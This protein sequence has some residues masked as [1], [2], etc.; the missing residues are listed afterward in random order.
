MATYENKDFFISYHQVDLEWAKWIA[1][2][3]EANGYS[4][5][6]KPWDFRPGSNF[7]LE[8]DNAL[9]QTKRILMVLS[10]DYLAHQSEWTAVVARNPDALLP[11]RVRECNPSGRLAVITSLDL[12]PPIEE[13][14]AR[15][16]LLAGVSGTR[17][18]PSQPP[19][20]P[21]PIPIFPGASNVFI[22]S[23]GDSPVVVSSMYDLLTQQEGLIIDRMVVLYPKGE[24]NAYKYV[25]EVLSDVQD[26]QPRELPFD[27]ADTSE[28]ACI[29]L[30]ELYTLLN[31]CQEKG[32]TVYLS[33][34]GG[35]KS[36]AALTAW[37]AP[38]FPCIK[39]LYHVID[40]Q[41]EN[42]FV[43]ADLD[44]Y[45]AS[46]RFKALHPDLSHLMLVK[47]PFEEN[48]IEQQDFQKLHSV[49]RS[50]TAESLSARVYETDMALITLQKIR[51]GGAFL[52]VEVS[53]QAAEQFIALR[54]ENPGYARVLSERIMQMSSI[55]S[56]LEQANI[57]KMDSQKQ[58]SGKS[59]SVILHSFTNLDIPVRPVFYTLPRD[60]YTHSDDQADRLIICS[61]EATSVDDTRSLKE[62]AQTSPFAMKPDVAFEALP[63]APSP[64][65]SILIVPLGKSPMVA[66]QLYTLLREQE[67]H[68]IH[69]VVLIYPQ[70][71]V[72]INNST[73]II[74]KALREEYNVS[75]TR[76][77]I[78]NL[79]DITSTEHCT[80]YQKRLEADIERIKQQ[81]P[82]HK[83][84]LALSGGRKGMTAMTIF[85]AQKTHIPYVYH[86]LIT[87]EEISEQ[88][89]RDTTIEILNSP[90]LS[91]QVRNN[92]LFLHD[93]KVE[94]YNPY[95]NFTLFRV[96]VFTADGW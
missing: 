81:Y 77:G 82:K 1:W 92:R 75:C 43:T 83:I 58:K 59:S 94:G 53:K 79:K 93:Y 16:R 33:L 5:V 87:N 21:G 8:E 7:V 40:K 95:A 96:P 9:D 32:D 19:R 78:P 36:M 42:F 15:D 68:T 72:E 18:S 67:Q 62:I 76:I 70:L 88:I 50:G 12:V 47:L 56:L 35:R 45:D 63:S 84:D 4:C 91:Q 73:D 90:R 34:A 46:R 28:N 80:I 49:L 89:E 17:L 27:D 31:A 57:F 30:K 51:Q 86:T 52:K 23:L 14:V 3:L 10:P 61:L 55:A 54:A 38:R 13:S 64:S 22:A 69:E 11:V 39:G 24:K 41:E 25:K 65:D 44:T 48:E 74:R 26:L 66:T 60:V 2:H 29:Y 85:A 37:V 71:S 6:I 20:Y